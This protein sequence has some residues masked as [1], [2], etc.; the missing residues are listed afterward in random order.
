LFKLFLKLGGV[1]SI[2][3]S[4]RNQGYWLTKNELLQLYALNRI[5]NFFLAN[6]YATKNWVV[7]SEKINKNK[8]SVIYNAVECKFYSKGSLEERIYFRKNLGFSSDAI[9]IGLVANLRPVNL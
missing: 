4:R 6:C 8:I 7:K 2:I 5:V 9:V 1:K 3:S